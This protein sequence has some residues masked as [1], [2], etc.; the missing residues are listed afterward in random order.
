MVK[1]GD[2]QRT[3]GIARDLWIGER[4]FVVKRKR[5]SC[6][7]VQFHM[8][9]HGLD[10]RT[11]IIGDKGRRPE[12]VDGRDPGRTATAVEADA[13]C[14]E[15][16]QTVEIVVADDRDVPSALHYLIGNL[17]HRRFDHRARQDIEA[18]GL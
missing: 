5:R 13:R 4:R 14:G 9:P 11:P 17:A 6:D 1:E 16:R 8:G 2:E 12:P 7:L 3:N 10:L 15:W 18:C